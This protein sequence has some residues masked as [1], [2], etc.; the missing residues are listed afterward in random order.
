[1]KRLD[2]KNRAIDHVR[3]LADFSKGKGIREYTPDALQAF[4]DETSR[5]L[6]SIV[7]QE[8]R[9]TGIRGEAMFLAV[10]AG[11]GK[12]RLI[13]SEDEGDVYYQG[14][15]VQSPDFRIV[16]ADGRGLL[17]EVKAIRMKSIH[18]KLKLSDTYVQQLRRYA[19]L[20]KT[21]LRLAIFWDRM[22]TWTLNPLAAFEA[23]SHGEKQWSIDFARAYG[24]SEMAIVG[25][26]FIG[27][28]APL[29]FR[30]NV[31]PDK[32][33]PLPPSS[34]RMR[35]TI[36][37]V[38]LVSRD[39]PLSGRATAIASKL[40]WHGNWVDAGQHV[41]RDGNRMLW[42]DHL[43]APTEDEEEW[44]EGC[45]MIG[46]LSSIISNAYLAGAAS[47]IHTSSNSTV[48]D[49]GSMGQFIPDDFEK[50]DLPLAL[51]ELRSNLEPE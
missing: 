25:D 22:R 14:E 48:L 44:G 31:D 11:I 29:R 2:R 45:A 12:V 20:M 49:P 24:T 7:T 36:A 21:D 43:F 32:S 34:G 18:A 3:L 17:V 6:A 8:S 4:A 39:R 19:D 40:L 9:L 50:L 16:L 27:T 30:V 35:V 47:T 41:E 42:V 37:S 15:A 33:D 10:V 1:M 38:Q 26:R 23:G 51:I 46:S 5:E 13:K 28:P